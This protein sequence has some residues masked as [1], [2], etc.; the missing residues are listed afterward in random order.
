[1][2]SIIIT[3][4]Y[5]GHPISSLGFHFKSTKGKPNHNHFST[6]IV[7]FAGTNDIIQRDLGRSGASVLFETPLQQL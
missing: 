3:R 1:M 4:R 2:V 7:L 5:W 6:L